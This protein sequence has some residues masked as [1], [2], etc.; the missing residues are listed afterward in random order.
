MGAFEY[1]ALDAAGRRYKGVLEGDTAR[2]VR[3]LLRDKS[4]LPVSV[5]EVAARESRSQRAGGGFSLLR[6]VSITDLSLLTRQLATLV[7]DVP[8]YAERIGDLSDGVLTKLENMEQTAHAMVAP[9]RLSQPSHKA[10]GDIEAAILHNR[11]LAGFPESV[12]VFQRGGDFY[13]EGETFKQPDLART[14]ERIALLGPAG[15]YE[16]ETAALLEKEMKAGGGLLTAADL[17][18]YEPRSRV[19]LQGTYRGYEV[20]GVPPVSSGGITLLLMLNVLEGYELRSKGALSA[21]SIHL[22]VEPLEQRVVRFLVERRHFAECV[23]SGELDSGIRVGQSF[24]EAR[25]GF[26]PGE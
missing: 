14:L 22:T 26:G 5:T 16:G 10:P 9:R 13:K 20:I 17:R 2:Q 12:R 1:T 25:L 3:S 21:A 24:D 19:A 8:K 4:L 18:A 6:R 11:N 23:R 7:E 15:F